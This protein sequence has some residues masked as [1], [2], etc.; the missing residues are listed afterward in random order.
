MDAGS[1][2]HSCAHPSRRSARS[3]PADT[4]TRLEKRTGLRCGSGDGKPL[5]SKPKLI[6]HQRTRRSRASCRLKTSHRSRIEVPQTR[7]DR[8]R[9]AVP[10]RC[11]RS[12]TATCTELQG[13][14]SNTGSRTCTPLQGSGAYLAGS[15]PR[16]NRG[17]TDTRPGPRKHPR[18][19]RPARRPLEGTGDSTA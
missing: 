12:D 10:R 11:P 2:T 18:W 1:E 4:C 17:H 14:L 5:G 13:L 3:S 6:R 8:S 7:G 16:E 19:C 15:V 9:S